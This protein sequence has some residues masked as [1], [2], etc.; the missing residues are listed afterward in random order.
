VDGVS[1]TGAIVYAII[2][3]AQDTPQR[4]QQVPLWLQIILSV[5]G[6]AVPVAGLYITVR[7]SRAVEQKTHFENQLLE[8]QVSDIEREPSTSSDRSEADVR[9]ARAVAASIET[10]VMRFILLFI[11]LTIW[12]SGIR[13]LLDVIE[14]ILNNVFRISLN[15]L[16][17]TE[18]TAV[19]VLVE[20]FF[21]NIL[22]IGTLII[23]FALGRPLL[24][25]I[26][27]RRAPEES[28]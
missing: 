19:N 27:R 9:S 24:A 25:D 14:K 28:S 4:Q 1:P 5:V 22:S 8:R 10:F 18:L 7:G 16:W 17:Q 23:L 13:F 3:V 12:S 11:A 15:D 20:M 6:T 2:A 21:D 26:A